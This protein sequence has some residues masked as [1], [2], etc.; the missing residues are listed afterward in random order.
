MVHGGEDAHAVRHGNEAHGVR[1]DVAEQPDLVAEDASVGVERERRAQHAVAA[2][3]VG[4]ERLAALAGPF[5]RPSDALRRPGHDDLLGIEIA[6]QAESAAHVRRNDAHALRR[7]PER[8]GERRLQAHHALI[9]GNEGAGAG[10]PVVI[11]DRG[12]RLHLAVGDAVVD[13]LAAHDVRRACERVSC[14]AG[15]AEFRGDAQVS[16]RLVPELRGALPQGVRRRYDRGQRLVFDFDPLG[17]VA[18]GECRLGQDRGERLAH[19]ARALPRQRPMRQ[20]DDSRAARRDESASANIQ[21]VDRVGRVLDPGEAVGEV[22]GAR[23]HRAHAG[24]APRP[25]RVDAHDA[26]VGVRRAQERAMELSLQIDVVGVTPG[27]G[28]KAPV[29]DARDRPAHI[30]FHRPRISSGSSASTSTKAMRQGLVPRFTQA[31]FVPRCTSTSPAFRWTSE[32]S[33]SMSISPDIT[34]A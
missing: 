10:A 18:R 2:L 9:A 22:I 19:V 28:E 4:H 27:P 33:S 29:L 17:R 11:A 3:V 5:H 26:R 32:S 12:A 20:L 14:G 6:S 30:A 34:T 24:S 21:R 8:R 25:A 1:A 15:V 16:G 23:E 31:W 13:E 7:H